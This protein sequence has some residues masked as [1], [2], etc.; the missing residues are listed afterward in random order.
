M[1]KIQTAYYKNQNTSDSQFCKRARKLRPTKDCESRKISF[2]VSVRKII[3]NC[4]KKISDR[5]LI[6]SL[7]LLCDAIMISVEMTSLRPSHQLKHSDEYIL[8][9]HP[10]HFVFVRTCMFT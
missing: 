9:A 3:P 1:D 10:L 7:M 5:I 6:F 4:S 8:R 2:K